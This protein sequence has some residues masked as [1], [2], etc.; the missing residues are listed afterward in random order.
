[1]Q[2]T[3]RCMTLDEGDRAFANEVKTRSGQN[4][5]RCMQCGKCTAGCPV[6]FE[7]DRPV[8]AMI[9]LIQ[10]GRREEALGSTFIWLCAQ[11]RT[12]SV[13]C[14]QEIDVAALMGALRSMSWQGGQAADGRV[15]TFLG[16]FVDSVR[17]HGRVYELGLMAA[18]ALKTGRMFDD[19]AL[20]PK[21]L[22]KLSIRPHTTP[23][24]DEVRA[25][26]ERAMK[27]G[28]V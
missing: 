22:P 23:G 13:R 16:A 9:R 10:E 19:M 8:N 26:I 15:R 2:N 24:A 17:R 14:P 4:A 11:C 3:N 20:A 7:A 6:G 1:M 12:C 21:A 25:V 5:S 18:Y 28:K 27:E